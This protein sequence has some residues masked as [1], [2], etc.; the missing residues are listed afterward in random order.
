MAALYDAIGE[1]FVVAAALT[2]RN[3]MRIATSRQ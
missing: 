2:G 1:R 3:Y